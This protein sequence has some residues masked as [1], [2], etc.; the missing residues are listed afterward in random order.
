MCHKITSF[1]TVFIAVVYGQYDSIITSLYM[2]VCAWH[3]EKSLNI[4]NKCLCN[5]H[6]VWYHTCSWLFP[7]IAIIPINK[8][9]FNP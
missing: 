3:Y 2:H 8:A 6:F 1:V 7:G 4:P 5:T 9:T